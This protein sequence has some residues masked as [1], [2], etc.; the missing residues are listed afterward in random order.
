MDN[1]SKSLSKIYKKVGIVSLI[2]GKTNTSKFRLNHNIKN[3]EV[4][5]DTITP[6]QAANKIYQ[7]YKNKK[8]LI[9]Y[10]C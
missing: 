8:I 6:L 3:N 5:S 7:I 2:L 1:V 9:R 10:F 4:L